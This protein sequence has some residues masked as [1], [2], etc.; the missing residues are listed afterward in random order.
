MVIEQSPGADNQGMGPQHS[1]RTT[2]RTSVRRLVVC[3]GIVLVVAVAEV[4]VGLA[5][6]SLA[7][8]GDAGHLST[9]IATLGLT[10]YAIARSRRPATARHTFGY[11]RSGILTACIN[12]VALLAV[13]ALLA[14]AAIARL[15]HPVD[16]NAG[17]VLV[18]AMFALAVNFGLA[19]I[20]SHGGDELSV[21]SA[22][23]H[24]IADAMASAGVIVSAGVILITGWRSADAMVS[25]LISALIAGAAISL[26]RTAF[27]ILAETTPPDIDV[28]KLKETMLSHHG[29]DGVH[30]LHIW[31]IDSQHRALS[32][33]VLVED[34]P[35]ADV[36]A[37][38]LNVERGL[39][40]DFGIEHVTLQPECASCA[41]DESLFCDF[42]ERHVVLHAEEITT[43]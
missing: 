2:E 31:S 3:A 23:L 22:A 42:D 30:D 11:H 40:A 8:L 41:G 14:L 20:L 28:A 17:P 6:G 4:V 5:S 38:L 1:E 34:R 7:L 24:V 37:L 35:L 27:G 12:G 13:A 18:I 21:R 43:H 25:L 32:A 9:D 15:Q 19:M 33:H 16:I 36:T 26:L 29:V 10:A 39:C